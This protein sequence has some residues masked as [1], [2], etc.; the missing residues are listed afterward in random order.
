MNGK[1][2]YVEKGD[3]IIGK[4]LT[5]SNKNGEEE[6]FDN[7]YVIKT[8]E[9]G[10]I[11]R[12][13][14]TYTSNGYKMIK[15]IIR[16]RKIP[17]IG[18]KLCSRSAQ[19]GTVGLLVAQEDMPFTKDGI[20]PD[21]LINSHCI[22]SRM[23]IAQLLET[24]LGKA[25]CFEGKLADGTPFKYNNEN[26]ANEI[27]NKLQE[28]GF[29]RHGNEELI[30]GM[31]GEPLEAKVMTG[32]VYYQRL[33]HMVSDKIHCLD[34]KTEI[35]TIDGWKTVF[36]LSKDDYIATLKD[37]NLVYEKPTNIMIYNDYVGSMYYISDEH[38]DF[39]V[40]GNHRMWV[41]KYNDSKNSWLS[42]NFERADNIIG[43]NRKYKRNA[44]Y[45]TDDY[46]PELLTR[47]FLISYSNKLEEKIPDWIL[48]LSAKQSR[49]VM[50]N[51]KEEI[52][53]SNKDF[54]NKIQQLC[55]HA[56][57]TANVD[58]LDSVNYIIKILKNI[59]YLNPIVKDFSKEKYIEKIKCP[60]FCVQVPSEVF[61]V[62][63]NGKTAW[64]GNSRSHGL[65]TSLCRQPLNILMRVIGKMKIFI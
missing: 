2:V 7:S 51:L 17:E 52:I 9:E 33:K 16:N 46:L 59:K 26:V 65:V 13:V 63:R 14:E 12:V 34:F 4:I 36:T 1:S 49:E 50:T 56:G 39:A 22:P 21:I 10:Y 57:Y 25:C 11:D 20:T 62:R 24:V 47:E 32:P 48:K 37:D 31:T 3:V 58:E 38:I 64:T 30:N 23:T 19:K 18:D 28:F 54:V 42:Y 55:L 6:I 40:T 15:V 44:V 29:E 8:G 5:K 45:V 27:S 43:S 61:Y 35:L 60:V 53:T 41:S